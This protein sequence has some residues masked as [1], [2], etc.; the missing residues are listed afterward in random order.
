MCISC[1][2]ALFID[3]LTLNLATWTYNHWVTLI[4]MGYSG[5]FFAM[6]SLLV[7]YQLAFISG[8]K[9]TNEFA[10]HK[11]NDIWDEGCAINWKNTFHSDFLIRYSL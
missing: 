2:T 10:R 9:T 1:I 11:E 6:L 7:I 5:I 8:G 3:P 4:V